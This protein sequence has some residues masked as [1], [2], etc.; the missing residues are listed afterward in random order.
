MSLRTFL[1]R[2]AKRLAHAGSVTL[3]RWTASRR[4]MPSFLIVGGQRCGTTSLYRA[5]AAHPAVLKAV[6]HKGVHWF[7]VNHERGIDWYRGHFPLHSTARRIAD[8]TGTP[9][10]AFESSPYYMYHPLA[11]QRIA[12]T[13]PDVRLIVLIRDPVERAYSQYV[14]E[15]ARGYETERDFA[16]ALAL[17]RR[18]LAG[19]EQRL[20]D[21]PGYYSHSH[22]HHA[23]VERGRYVE[24]LRRLAAIF[25]RGRIH[26]VESE[27]FFA[28]PEP[29]YDSILAFLG[30]PDFGYP[31][32]DRHNA[33]PR[34]PMPEAVRDRLTRHFAPYNDMLASWLGFRPTF[35][36][37]GGRATGRGTPL[38]PP[39]R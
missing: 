34:S 2:P 33:R 11:P 22:Q 18:R 4:I 36:D 23:Y 29:V 35:A 14:H 21:I 16:V 8:R 17:E 10:Q 3:G 31:R 27:A 1:P 12:A 39:G 5:L 6:L 15:L 20:R 37:P 30:L 26:V 25:G 9:A 24:H 38:A 7:D 28:E 32:F 13:L 19:E